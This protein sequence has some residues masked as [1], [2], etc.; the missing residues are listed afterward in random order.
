ML[1]VFK[2]GAPSCFTFFHPILSTLS[3]F[4]NPILTPLPLTGFS[5]LCSH[6]THSRSGILSPDATHAS[7]GIIIFV[8][9][10]LLFSELST[11][12][13]SLLD[14]YFA[15]AEVNI[16]LNNSSSLSFLNVYAPHYLLFPDGWQ[17]R[18]LFSLFI[19]EDFNCYYSLWDSK[20]TSDSRGEEIF[21]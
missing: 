10:G 17:I 3:V 9:Q 2:P 6:R 16:S 8:R 20:G 5:A 13:L 14:S 19:L 15:Y 1:E 12:S 11:F 21:H 4:R 18:L 7:G